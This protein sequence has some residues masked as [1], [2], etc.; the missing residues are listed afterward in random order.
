MSDLQDPRS[1]PKSPPEDA[2]PVFGTW[3]RIYTAVILSNLVVMA[4]VALFSRW[5]F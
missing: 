4:L 2:V 5:A 3:A 1:E